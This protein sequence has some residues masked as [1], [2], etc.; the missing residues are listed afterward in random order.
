[1]NLNHNA[2]LGLVTAIA[3]IGLFVFA[4][5]ASVWMKNTNE[6]IISFKPTYPK[7]LLTTGML[8]WCIMSFAG[9]S[10]FLYWN[11]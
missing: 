4:F 8:F 6:R 9:V 2:K 11:F 7:A 1:M 5:V 10:S 3:I